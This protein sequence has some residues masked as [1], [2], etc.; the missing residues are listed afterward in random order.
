MTKIFYVILILSLSA[1]AGRSSIPIHTV[2]IAKPAVVKQTVTELPTTGK[3]LTAAD[4][5]LNAT[6]AKSKSVATEGGVSTEKISKPAAVNDLSN[7]AAG[8]NSHKYHKDIYV[9]MTATEDII[10]HI[11]YYNVPILNFL[12]GSKQ[13]PPNGKNILATIDKNNEI[14][15]INGYSSKG[16]N[17]NLR[18]SRHR[19]ESVASALKSMGFDLLKTKITGF[20]ETDRLGNRVY[21]QGVIIIV[22]K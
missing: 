9:R 14:V 21:C 18:L 19:A 16:G 3:E 4:F 10:D 12:S 7:K 2:T 15:A 1:C 5:S 8:V 22:K 13:I 6:P 20:G 17:D 11:G